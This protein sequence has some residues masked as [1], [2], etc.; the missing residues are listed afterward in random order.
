MKVMCVCVSITPTHLGQKA[1]GPIQA[2]VQVRNAAPHAWYFK[3]IPGHQ[4]GLHL[5]ACIGH[6][7]VHVV[8]NKKASL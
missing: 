1:A 4:P 7:C 2:Y 3:W 5:N 8:L 6:P